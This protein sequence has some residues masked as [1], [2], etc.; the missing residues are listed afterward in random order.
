MD[1]K[2]SHLLKQFYEEQ[3]N[4]HRRKNLEYGNFYFEP[5]SVFTQRFTAKERIETRIDEKLGRVSSK[6]LDSEIAKD[7]IG[8]LACWIVL[9]KLE[10][11]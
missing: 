11:E 7:I 2:Y 5:I 4:F 9:D 3:S 6:G 1:G 10:K 8:C